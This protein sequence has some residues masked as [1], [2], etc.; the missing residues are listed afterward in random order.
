MSEQ[1]AAAL[2]QHRKNDRETT[3]DGVKYKIKV[4]P[5][6]E[7]LKRG[8]DLTK[9]LAPAFG[10]GMDG[11]MAADDYINPPKT[12][13]D[14]TTILATQIDKIDVI[15]LVDSLLRDLE[16]ND[17]RVNIN[18]YFAGDIASMLLVIEFA[19]KE[20]FGSLF[21]GKGIQAR[22]MGTLNKILA[23]MPEK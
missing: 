20:N 21:T 13:T 16:V 17:N 22:L 11:L 19:L 10:S 2:Q 6:M 23:F 18:D 12:F 9:L 5:A 3:I 1:L 4:L 15:D 7:S 8:L 14:L